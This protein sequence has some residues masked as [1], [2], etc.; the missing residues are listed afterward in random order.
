MSLTVDRNDLGDVTHA[1]ETTDRTSHLPVVMFYSNDGCYLGYGCADCGAHERLLGPFATPGDART[2]WNDMA[3]VS[4]A[5]D[6]YGD[7]AYEEI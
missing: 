4:P 1:C 3:R 7:Y 5:L 2:E 6:A